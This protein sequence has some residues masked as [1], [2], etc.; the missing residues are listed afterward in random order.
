MLWIHI[1]AVKVA[2]CARDGMHQ[3][4]GP[5]WKL[6]EDCW[7]PHSCY[8]LGFLCW[9]HSWGQDGS[10]VALPQ[11]LHLGHMHT[12]PGAHAHT[13]ARAVIY[14][15]HVQLCSKSKL[16]GCS[17]SVTSKSMSYGVSSMPRP[18]QQVSPTKVCK[19][20]QPDAGFIMSFMP[21]PWN[22]KSAEQGP[23][24]MCWHWNVA[25]MS[26]MSMPLPLSRLTARRPALQVVTK[27]DL[28]HTHIPPI[29]PT[30]PKNSPTTPKE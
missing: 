6:E 13:V 28:C 15:T 2:R 17:H 24:S 16:Q 20:Q 25:E 11:H 23:A 7:R 10:R 30:T 12:L 22:H 18:W 1:P 29:S 8:A 27:D 4:V 26:Q 19:S 3:A 14:D 21:P 5:A 9:N